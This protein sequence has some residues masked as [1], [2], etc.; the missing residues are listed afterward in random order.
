MSLIY[1]KHIFKEDKRYVISCAI[2]FISLDAAEELN[3]D[4]DNLIRSV[5]EVIEDMDNETE[6]G[7]Y[8]FDGFPVYIGY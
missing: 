6:Y 3:Y 1:Y 7:N 5:S 8:D 2:G 4:Y